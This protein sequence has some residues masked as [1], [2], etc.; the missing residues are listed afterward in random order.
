MLC[1]ISITHKNVLVQYKS[2]KIKLMP[3]VN[4]IIILVLQFENEMNIF[5]CLK[6]T[7]KNE[8]VA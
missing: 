5:A 8:F 2:I 6:L 4:V 1:E 7:L 3:N